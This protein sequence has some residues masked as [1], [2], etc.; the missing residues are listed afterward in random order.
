MVGSRVCSLG[1]PRLPKLRQGAHVKAGLN[2]RAFEAR[3]HGSGCLIA[4]AGVNSG[5]PSADTEHRG[6]QWELKG[7]GVGVGIQ[8][9][10]GR[11]WGDPE[12]RGVSHIK[13][14]VRS[15]KR[16]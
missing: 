1:A 11:V 14:L 4:R 15:L 16:I 13:K 3:R 12:E 10:A 7:G 5:V 2:H 8:L 6:C 9:N